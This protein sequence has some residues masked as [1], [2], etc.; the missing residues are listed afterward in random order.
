MKKDNKPLIGIVGKPAILSVDWKYMNISDNIRYSIIKNGGLAIGIVP[1]SLT[2]D[3]NKSD[4]KDK[5]ELSN[6]EKKDLLKI[7]K[8]CQGI[9]LQG[10]LSSAGYETEIVKLAIKNK[11]PI[12][13]IC[14]G[15]NN[16]IRA[17]GGD[18]YKLKNNKIHNKFGKKYAHFVKIKEGTLLFNILGK[19][20]IRVNSIHTM[21]ANDSDIKGL[22]ISAISEDGLVEAVESTKNNYV[23][24]IKWHPELM[25]NYSPTMNKIFKKFIDKCR[26]AKL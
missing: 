12:L 4:T 10:G 26:H 3:F 13:G 22:Q 2:L 19:E 7:I 23:L 8:N 24:G 25:V 15:F 6:Q 17:F 5:T 21:V 18:V 1:T 9:V 11:I 16:I 14:A 20:K